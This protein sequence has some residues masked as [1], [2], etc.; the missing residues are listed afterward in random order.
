MKGPVVLERHC[1]ALREEVEFSSARQE[2]LALLTE[3]NLNFQRQ[4]SSR[5]SKSSS[6]R[7]RKRWN[8]HKGS[9]SWS[10]GKVKGRGQGL[11]KVGVVKGNRTVFRSPRQFL[12]WFVLIL[13]WPLTPTKQCLLPVRWQKMQK[14]RCLNRLCKPR[15]ESAGDSEEWKGVVEKK[16]QHGWIWKVMGNEQFVRGMWEYLTL[17]R[18]EVKKILEDASREK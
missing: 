6:R 3:G 15:L 8:S 9:T 5:S 13:T 7:H 10:N 4:R 16:A 17:E 14:R 18:A 1:L 2:V 12:L 11:C